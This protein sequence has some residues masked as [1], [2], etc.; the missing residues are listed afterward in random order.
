MIFGK[1][2]KTPIIRAMKAAIRTAAAEIS[3]I[4]PALGLKSGETKFT[5]VSMAV[6]KS[7][8]INTTAVAAMIHNHSIVFS[9]K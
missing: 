4:R 5:K 6:L 1:N 2:I 8:A 3:L 7:S 9:A